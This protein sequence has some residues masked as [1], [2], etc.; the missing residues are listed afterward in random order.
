MIEIRIRG[1][2]VHLYENGELRIVLGGD[3]DNHFTITA[4][5]GMDENLVQIAAHAWLHLIGKNLTDKDEI[6]V[7]VGFFA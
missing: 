4:F 5:K 7:P 3:V 6:P 2:Y 1:K